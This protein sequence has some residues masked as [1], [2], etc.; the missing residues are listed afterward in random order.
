MEYYLIQFPSREAHVQVV[1]ALSQIPQTRVG[2]P[3]FAMIVV[4]EHID[5]LEKA[6]V[7]FIEL[8]VGTLDK[9]IVTD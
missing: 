9:Q 4:K 7:A 5:C 6:G 8:P 3:D 1:A 2:L